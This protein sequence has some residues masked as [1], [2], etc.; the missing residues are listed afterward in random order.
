MTEVIKLSNGIQ[1][2][3]EHL[4]YLRTASLGIWIRVG[5]A[6]EMKNNNGI[7][8]MIEHMLF[9]GTTTKTAKEIADVISKIGD[10]VNAFTGKE[11]TCYY[12]ST[13]TSSL[14]RLIDLLADMLMNSRFDD[15][16]LEKEKRV[17]CD[18]ID[19]YEDSPEDLVHELLQRK[20][21]GEH[22]LGYI[23]SGNKTV[24]R[25][26]TG[27]QLKA[28]M[29]LHYT[30][31]NIIISVAGNYEREALIA[32]LESCFSK[33]RVGDKKAALVSKQLK[34]SQM[35]TV[36]P[37]QPR[38]GYKDMNKITYHSCFCTRNKDIEQLHINLAFPAIS[39]KSSKNDIFSVF[40]SILGGSNNS[41]LFQKIR[42]DLGLAYSIYSYGSS[43]ED[44]GLLHIDIT[45]NPAQANLVMDTTWQ[46][47]KEIRKDGITK[48]ELDTH[49]SQVMTE[50]I[51]GSE[52]AKSRMNSN[53]KSLM[54]RGHLRELDDIINNI[55]NITLKEINCF[56]KEVLALD[57]VS[58]C[59]VGPK[60][61]SNFTQMKQ[62]WMKM[63]EE[64]YE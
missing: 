2:S 32:K 40:N 49:K 55:N 15:K 3:L 14:D 50:L 58:I 48:E 51:M 35:I 59:L 46:V 30:A 39:L 29:K 56:A 4:P 37:Y 28:F 33:L 18:E 19:M 41:K 61:G 22:A 23:I 5:S 21:Y 64:Q 47:L 12:G 45:V 8:H 60:S 7:S 54:V 25:S 6:Y 1:V 13:V 31:D 27:Q 10:D 57:K 44:T 52:S 24:V 9:K 53:A 42:E 11:V 43:F 34:N 38:Y 26:F 20:I 62:K 36:D 17:I 16:D 63:R